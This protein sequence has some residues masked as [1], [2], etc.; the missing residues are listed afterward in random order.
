ML[1]PINGTA[2]FTTMQLIS[3]LCLPVRQPAYK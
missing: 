1:Q 2:K 3:L